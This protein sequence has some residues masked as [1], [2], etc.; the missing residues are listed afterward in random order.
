MSRYFVCCRACFVEYLGLLDSMA[1][2][3]LMSIRKNLIVI[4]ID[5]NHECKDSAFRHVQCL[6]VLQVVSYKK[7]NKSIHKHNPSM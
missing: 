6:S 7:Q 2:T 3:A 5:Q 4:Y 1:Y